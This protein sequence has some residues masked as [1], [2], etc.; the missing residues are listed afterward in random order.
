VRWLQDKAWKARRR[1]GERKEHKNKP[2]NNLRQRIFPL[3]A[4][5][6]EAELPQA[7]NKIKGATRKSMQGLG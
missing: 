3:K 7:K 5:L 4:A 2:Q 6:A 1:T